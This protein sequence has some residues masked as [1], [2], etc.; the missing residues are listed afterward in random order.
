MRTVPFIISASLLAM[1]CG[2]DD[3]GGSKGTGGATGTG[4]AAGSATGGT[5]G[6]ATG[7]QAGSATGGAG[8]ATAACAKCLADALQGPCSTQAAACQGESG[9]VAI[10]ACAGQCTAGD[11]VCAQACVDN[12]P[13]GKATFDALAL[14]TDPICKTACS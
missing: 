2:S 4:G 12:N 10:L 11:T 8:G 7:G 1:A 5:A 14:C 6:S 3:D 13:T 9:C